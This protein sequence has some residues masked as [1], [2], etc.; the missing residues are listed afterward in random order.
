VKRPCW[1]PRQ[2]SPEEKIS[3][4][5]E[6]LLALPLS[7]HALIFRITLHEEKKNYWKLVQKT[8]RIIEFSN[9]FNSFKDFPFPPGYESLHFIQ[10][11]IFHFKFF[12][13]RQNI[14]NLISD[15]PSQ[16]ESLMFQKKKLKDSA[17]FSSGESISTID[18]K[19]MSEKL[20]DQKT[21]FTMLETAGIARKKGKHTI[22][23]R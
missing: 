14:L 7:M 23:G 6:I 8:K 17:Q 9:Y 16:I 4:Y 20:M 15:N 12:N 5:L 22:F 10:I 21:H 19:S 13:E 3:D 2:R 1:H 11:C 18:L